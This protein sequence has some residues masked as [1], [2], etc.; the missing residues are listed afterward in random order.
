MTV[1]EMLQRI[2]SRELT[3]W[4]TYYQL[5]ATVATEPPADNISV[6]QPIQEPQEPAEDPEHWRELLARAEAI[7]A[8]FGG[9]DE[10]KTKQA[11]A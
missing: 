2:S 7:N 3:E 8:A 5:E 1:A 11:G 4:A 6:T 10:R 9:S